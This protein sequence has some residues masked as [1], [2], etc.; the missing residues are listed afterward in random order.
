M[1][2]TNKILIGSI[3]AAMMVIIIGLCALCGYFILTNK[4]GSSGQISGAADINTVNNGMLFSVQDE[5]TDIYSEPEMSSTVLMQ[6]AKGDTVQFISLAKDG[7][8][9]IKLNGSTGYIKADKI[10]D[11]TLATPAPADPTPEPEKI[12]Y[13]INV[14]NAVYLRKTPDMNAENLSTI[15]LGTAVTLVKKENDDFSRIRYN[16]IEGYVLNKFLTDDAAEAA[17]QLQQKQNTKQIPAGSSD[18]SVKS[19]MY[20]VNVQNAIYLRTGPD[21]NADVITTI[22]VG[23]KVGFIVDMGNGFYK[24]TWNGQMGYS[25][26]QYLS[27]AS[28]YSYSRTMYVSGVEHSVYLRRSPSEYT[29]YITE[30][31]LGAAV[32]FLEDMGNGYYKVNYNGSVGYVTAMYLR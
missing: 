3:I 15:S 10:I 9:K 18:V 17:R 22:P 4:A 25:K 12:V 7:F 11:T 14:D 28:P 2:K 19:Y 6:C 26:A 27:Y 5:R 29:S 1:T 24:I 20:V 31:P 8:Y 13:I 21:D 23:S 30:I 16:G 32:T